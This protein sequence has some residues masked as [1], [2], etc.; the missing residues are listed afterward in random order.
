MTPRSRAFAKGELGDFVASWNHYKTKKL[1]CQYINLTIDRTNLIYDNILM[2]ETKEWLNLK[3]T[4]AYV[5]VTINTL[6]MIMKSKDGFPYSKFS[7]RLIRVNKEE[8]D[9]WLIDYN[10]SKMEET[11]QEEGPEH[12]E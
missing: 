4:A 12:Y 7:K 9:K 1:G 2:T 5:G 10:R 3:E 11:I 6:Y 8:L